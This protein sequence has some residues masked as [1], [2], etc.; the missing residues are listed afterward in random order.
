MKESLN[1]TPQTLSFSSPQNMC[2]RCDGL[3]RS[4]DFD[5]DLFVPDPDTPFL[6]GAIGQMRSPN[7]RWRRHIFRCV[8]EHVGF[9]LKARWRDL[10]VCV[11]SWL[12]ENTSLTLVADDHRQ[13]CVVTDASGRG[14][15]LLRRAAESE[16]VC[17]CDDDEDYCVAVSCR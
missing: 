7:R 14:K 3:G 2:R 9:D 5:L 10:V 4:F 16:P 15:T 17:L 6:D 8:A 1:P 11:K 13:A 12:P